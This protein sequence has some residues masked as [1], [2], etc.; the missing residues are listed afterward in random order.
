MPKLIATLLFLCT[1]LFAQQKGTFTD[2]RNGKIYKTVKIGEQ[3]WM[4]ENLNYEAEE[5]RCYD[6]K[7]ANCDK[8]GRL[9]DWYMAM[10]VCPKGWHLPTNEEWDI[11]YHYVDGTSDTSSPYESK[12]AGKFLKAMRGWDKNGN[13]NDKFGFAA[14][15]GGYGI[16]G[17]SFNYVGDFGSWW[18]ANEINSKEAYSRVMSNY[19][20]TAY[21]GHH[22]KSLLFSIRCLQNNPAPPKGE[23]K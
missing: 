10:K 12:T 13:G 16:S 19:D 14:L 8:Y 23:A 17:S 21:W 2:T 6:N 7:Q 18:S 22:G 4:A 15:P 9:Y 3:V 5:S 20:E 11:L 1:A